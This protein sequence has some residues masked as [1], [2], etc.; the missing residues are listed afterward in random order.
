MDTLLAIR[1]THGRHGHIQECIVQNFRAKAGTRM[2][3]SPEPD[4]REM[5]AT[6]ALARLLLPEI[7]L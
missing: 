4:E 5:L 7:T 1:Q 2:E 6:I 3:N